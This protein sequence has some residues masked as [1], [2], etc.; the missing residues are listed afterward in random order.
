MPTQP[1]WINKQLFPFE[2]KWIQ[3]NG[4]AQHYID[5]GNGDI[6]LALI[7]PAAFGDK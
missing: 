5:E 7:M 2:S 4:N 6:L 1:L 3:I